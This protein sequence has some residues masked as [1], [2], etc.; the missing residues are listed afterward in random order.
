[1][2]S[3]L[4]LC[5]II[6][7]EIFLS[8]P[9]AAAE[10]ENNMLSLQNT[11]GDILKQPEFSGFAQKI[12]PWDETGRNNPEIKISEISRLMPYHHNIVPE[13]VLAPLN[14]LI[15]EAGNGK[16]IFY[17][18]YPDSD[19]R[20]ENT[21]LFFFRGAPD[22]PF[23]IICPGGGFS[24]VGSLH[25]GFPLA[26][27]LS[28]NGYNAFVLKYRG[29]SA[30][31]A[32]QDLAAA[33]SYIFAHVD[34]LNVSVEDYSV[35]GGSAGAR[36]AAYI[37]SYGVKAFGGDHLPKP[38]AVIMAYTGHNDFTLQHPPTF[39]IVGEN[40][41]IAD[42]KKMKLYAEAL[43]KAGIKTEFHSYP[44]LGHGFGS[45]TNTSAA[46]WIDKAVNFWKNAKK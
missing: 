23:A 30:D 1:M 12:L 46:G 25:E 4:K 38:A 20:R 39:M 37:G 10:K 43:N 35:W 28:E 27:K 29:G 7:A 26:L 31:Q 11:V 17:D 34:I 14:Y 16:Q 42:P 9:V 32:M 13:D 22:A 8:L 6:L 19:K 45:G 40:D 24:Y 33:V 21:G 2:S 15:H 3:R 36:M 44:D 41:G 18:I 5:K